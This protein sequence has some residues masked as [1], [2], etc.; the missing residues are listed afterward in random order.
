M[1]IVEHVEYQGWG[2]FYHPTVTLV[3]PYLEPEDDETEPMPGETD[4]EGNADPDALPGA[5]CVDE[6]TGK[7]IINFD[8]EWLWDPNAWP[9]ELFSKF[10]EGAAK[11]LEI[12]RAIEAQDLCACCRKPIPFDHERQIDMATGWN[13]HLNCKPRLLNEH[14]QKRQAAQ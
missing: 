10:A 2:S 9:L 4:A 8:S 12:G 6:I 14:V 7:V 3:F 11:A 1:K 13:Y 5:F